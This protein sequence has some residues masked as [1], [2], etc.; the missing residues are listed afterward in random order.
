MKQLRGRTKNDTSSGDLI[1]AQIQASV[2]ERRR[3]S[4]AEKPAT[5]AIRGRKSAA[6]A[7]ANARLAASTLTIQSEPMP[8]AKMLGTVL[9]NARCCMKNMSKL[10]FSPSS[11][12]NALFAR[13][14]SRA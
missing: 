2:T 12:Q 1:T 14:T 7:A 10:S 8:T 11:N 9:K 3:T 5:N 4:P 13:S 6:F